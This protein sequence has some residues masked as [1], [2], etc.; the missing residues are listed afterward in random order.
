[1]SYGLIYLFLSHILSLCAFLVMVTQ[2]QRTPTSI[3]S[4]TLALAFLPYISGPLYFIIGIRKRTAQHKPCLSS[5]TDQAIN[6]NS[7]NHISD[8]LKSYGLDTLKKSKLFELY[9]DGV[10]AYHALYSAIIAAKHSIYISTY[11]FKNDKMTRT[12]LNAMIQKVKEG[13]TVKLLIDSVGS[14]Q[15]YFNFIKRYQIKK[16]GIQLHFFMPLFTNPFKN[17]INLRNHRKIYLIDEKTLFT[18]GMNLAN[19][20]MGP[21]ISQNRWQDLLF[22]LE[23]EVVVSF[24]NIFS[25]DW[26]YATHEILVQKTTTDTDTDIAMN[27]DDTTNA[28]DLIQV[29]PSGPDIEQDALYNALLNQIYA[30]QKR[31]WI[32]T[33][34]F[35]PPTELM[36]ALL[37]AKARGIDV[38]LITPIKSNHSLA[39]IGRATYIDTLKDA[40]I[41]VCLFSGSMVHAKAILLD[42]IV[43]LGSINL[44]YRS[45]F[46]NY[47]LG[48]FFHS[49]KIAND[50]EIWMSKFMI[51]THFSI[52]KK[53]I[54]K[55]FFE[56]LARIFTPLL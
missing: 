32:I 41:E 4:W 18:G 17:T 20:Y 40:N 48:V 39:D 52:K 7:D 55:K 36:R 33:P 15:L 56:R 30:T 45:L 2:K 51:P 9:V 46:L 50:I 42:D 21:N 49:K 12:L 44:D 38:K 34:Y 10:N 26:Q 23:G 31:I 3:I 47:E 22:R 1:M 8:I 35:V 16:S 28:T 25:H 19:E 27:E 6:P 29:A 53:S 43:M 11:V 13:I 37:I 5:S 24:Y 54:L 14:W